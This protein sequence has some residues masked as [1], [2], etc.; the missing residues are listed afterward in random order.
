MTRAHEAK[1]K[2]KTNEIEEVVLNNA[3]SACNQTYELAMGV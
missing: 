1:K 2:K 3:D